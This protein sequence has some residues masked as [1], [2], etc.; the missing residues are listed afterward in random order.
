MKLLSYFIIFFFYIILYYFFMNIIEPF[1]DQSSKLLIIYNDIF[2]STFNQYNP[3]LSLNITLTDLYIQKCYI[4][5]MN[6]KYEYDSKPW[7]K[8]IS[9]NSILDYI[10]NICKKLNIINITIDSNIIAL[11]KS[12]ITN[13]LYK[14]YLKSKNTNYKYHY[15]NNIVNLRQCYD[16]LSIMLYNKEYDE[17]RWIDLVYIMFIN[18][19]IIFI[20]ENIKDVNILSSLYNKI[21]I[22]GEFILEEL[23]KYVIEFHN[24][25]EDYYKYIDI[26]TNIKYIKNKILYKDDGL[27]FKKNHNFDCSI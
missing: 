20:K 14:T 16:N 7:L 6:N 27:Y 10:N 3:Y 13:L 22:I 5:K 11:Q 8:L 24:V 4:I 2:Q 12:Y 23:I 9:V 17:L 26:K 18:Y 19:N 1:N 25:T 21:I 15:Y